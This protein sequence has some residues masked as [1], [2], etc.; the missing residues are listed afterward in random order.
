MPDSRTPRVSC[1]EMTAV[2]TTPTGPLLVQPTGELDFFEAQR[3]ARSVG[4][5][6]RKRST[7]IVLDLRRLTFCDSSGVGL[8]RTLRSLAEAESVG[9]ELH[10]DGPAAARVFDVLGA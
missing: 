1:L 4:S 9:F 7:A 3:L 8:A 2:S 6:D 10:R 5:R